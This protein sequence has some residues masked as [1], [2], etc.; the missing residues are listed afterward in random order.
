LPLAPLL[1]RAPLAAGEGPRPIGRGHL[2]HS[3]PERP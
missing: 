3:P 1:S 2:W